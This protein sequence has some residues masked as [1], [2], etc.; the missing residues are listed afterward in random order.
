MQTKFHTYHNTLASH[1][2]SFDIVHLF[3]TSTLMMSSGDVA[4]ASW[5]EKTSWPEVVGLSIKEAEAIILKD[6]PNADIFPVPVGSAVIMDVQPNRVRIFV[7]IVAE[8][9]R[10]G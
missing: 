4:A 8:I 2:P 5:C 1:D 7:D 6:K 10:V 9:P 3:P